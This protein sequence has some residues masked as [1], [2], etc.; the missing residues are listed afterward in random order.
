M[1]LG[2]AGRLDDE[3]L[4]V[5]NGALG[6]SRHNLPKPK[7]KDVGAGV[8]DGPSRRTLPTKHAIEID[9]FAVLELPSFYE[10]SGLHRL[11]AG[12]CYALGDAIRLDPLLV[13]GL[14]N[15]AACRKDDGQQSNESHRRPLSRWNSIKKPQFRK[16]IIDFILEQAHIGAPTIM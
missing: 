16:D 13:G 8:K 12:Q 11:Q 14:M 1:V 3:V 6:R 7:G 15:R 4:V 5:L 9:G 10:F 2:V